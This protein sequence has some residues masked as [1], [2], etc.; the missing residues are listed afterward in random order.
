LTGHFFWRLRKG[1][2]VGISKHELIPVAL[3]ARIVY[4]R[5]YGAAPPEAHLN[6]RLNGLAYCLASRGRVYAIADRGSPPR[7]L[8]RDEIASGHF[9]NG[10][11]ELHFLD[12]RAPLL[13]IGVTQDC[14]EKAV[15]ALQA[16]LP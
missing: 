14:I 13:H 7:R 11:K 2:K 1:K 12:E 4:Q 9:R 10:G 5:A 8:S 3:A 16:A 6:D 15:K